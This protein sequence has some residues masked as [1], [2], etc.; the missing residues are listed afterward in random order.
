[1]E[2]MIWFLLGF[3]LGVLVVYIINNINN[4]SHGGIA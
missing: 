1:M 4:N 3:V 2:T